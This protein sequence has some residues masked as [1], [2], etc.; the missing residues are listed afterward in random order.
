MNKI[1]GKRW[2]VLR[3]LGEGGQAHTFIVR[4]IDSSSEKK[5]VIKLIKSPKGISRLKKEIKAIK[6]LD[7]PNIVKLVDYQIESEEPYLITEYC[8]G[9]NLQEA[10]PYWRDDPMIA[11]ELFLQIC[12]GISYAHQNSVIHRDIKPKNIF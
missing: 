2:E 11:I 5:Y 6:S 10:D 4:D 3:P 8:E 1:Y 12:S 9:G 7:H